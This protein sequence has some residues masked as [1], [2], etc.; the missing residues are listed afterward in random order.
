MSKQMTRLFMGLVVTMVLG[1]GSGARGA[2]ISLQLNPVGGSLTVPRGGT[3]SFDILLEN[4]SSLSI[5]S[6]QLNWGATDGSL[7]L[8]DWTR[9]ATDVAGWLGDDV[10]D[11][12]GASDLS[13]TG[14]TGSPIH[15]GKLNVIAPDAIG[16]YLLTVNNPGAISGFETFATYWDGNSSVEIQIADFGDRRINVVPEPTVIVLVALGGA[17]MLHRRR[18]I[19]MAC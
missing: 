15:I 12:V 13:L 19:K 16:T 8:A 11:V 4:L 10:M 5:D 18:Q 17:A 3:L 9:A 2:V 1:I 14:I 7:T 6:Y